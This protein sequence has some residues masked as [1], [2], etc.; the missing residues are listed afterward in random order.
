MR[1]RC[2]ACCAPHSHRRRLE[3]NSLSFVFFVFFV[4]QSF[5]PYIKKAVMTKSIIN[6]A[7]EENTT[8]RVV[9]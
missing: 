8:V 5:Q 4:V 3:P 1:R 9:A 2:R 6:V 7:I